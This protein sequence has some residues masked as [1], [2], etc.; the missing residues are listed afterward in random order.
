MVFPFVC[1]LIMIRSYRASK[2]EVLRHSEYVFVYR[3]PPTFFYID[4]AVCAEKQKSGFVLIWLFLL[5]CYT[6]SVEDERSKRK[7]KKEHY[8]GWD[9][10]KSLISWSYNWRFRFYWLRLTRLDKISLLLRSVFLIN[11]FVSLIHQ[12]DYILTRT[13]TIL[14]AKCFIEILLTSMFDF[15]FN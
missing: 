8:N 5:C 10:V 4:A 15:F 12:I 1:V 14:T 2:Q 6:R 11:D 13:L 7:W 9:T 3:P